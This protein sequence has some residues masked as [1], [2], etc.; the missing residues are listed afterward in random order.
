MKKKS[1]LKEDNEIVIRLQGKD[2]ET[3]EEM[4][5]EHL[6]PRK[7]VKRKTKVIIKMKPK[8]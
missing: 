7:E 4:A 3:V 1:H 5:C 8:W 2:E 6:D